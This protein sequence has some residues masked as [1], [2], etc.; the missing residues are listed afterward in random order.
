MPLISGKAAFL[1]FKVLGGSPKRLDDKLLDKLRERAA[2]RRR[3]EGAS[4]GWLGGRHILDA[5]FDIEK[6]I[7]LDCL[8]F[9]MRIDSARIPPDLLYAYTQQ[10]LEALL[11]NDRPAGT[12]ARAERRHEAHDEAEGEDSAHEEN[13][14]GNGQP[15][16][17]RFAK[18]KKQAVDAARGRAAQEI[19]QGR[20]AR[21]QQAPILWDTRS[22][23]LFVGATT[24]AVVEQFIPLF[25]ETFDRRLEP[26]TAGQLAHQWAE[27]RGLERR[28]E[29]MAA[30]EFIDV[31]EHDD[32]D[33][34]IYWTAHDPACRD[35][36]G[37][38]FLVWLWRVLAEETDAIA[39][40]DN[41]DA[42]VILVKQLLL[43]CPRAE[44]GKAAFTADGPASM[45]ESRRALRSGKLPRKAGM[46]LSRQGEQY[47]L[48]L[49][50]E[51]FGVTGAALPRIERNGG[52]LRGW[53]EERVEQMRH[54]CATLDAL[55]GAFLAKRLSDEWPSELARIREWMR[56]EAA[57]AGQ[58]A[59]QLPEVVTA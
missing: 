7:L 38:E 3:G 42:S 12:V 14:N 55:Y 5:D 26:I 34:A 8:H 47:E 44:T 58:S 33:R 22:D 30:S 4:V 19:R 16:G 36:L 50:A 25:R 35:F 43:E 31:P 24:P 45:P 48:T 27:A 40:D 46:I 20:Y 11:R 15:A 39:L 37:N 13:G 53:F 1:R 57:S 41:S 59:R 52:G 56:A 10:E 17:R 54:L 9:G 2:G 51:T 49:Q 23:T 28:L 29:A 6:N 32:G 18:L 21:M